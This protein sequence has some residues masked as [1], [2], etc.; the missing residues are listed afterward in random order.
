MAKIPEFRT[1]DEA[2]EFWESQGRSG[3]WE[4]KKEVRFEVHLFSLKMAA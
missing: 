1:L 3:Y 4:D 2:V